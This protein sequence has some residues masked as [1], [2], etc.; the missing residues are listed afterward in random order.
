ALV[1]IVVIIVVKTGDTV[2]IRPPLFIAVFFAAALTPK[3]S[4]DADSASG[5]ALGQM[6][7]AKKLGIAHPDQVADFDYSTDT[8]TFHFYVTAADGV[9]MRH[10]SLSS[11]KL[12]LRLGGGLRAN[13]TRRFR[14]V[15]GLAPNEPADEASARRNCRAQ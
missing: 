6:V 3:I 4:A 5:R 9:V 2:L 7:L 1:N 8:D 10:Q 14:I 13:E 12:A 15:P 11:G